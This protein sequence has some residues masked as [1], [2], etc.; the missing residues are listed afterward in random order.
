ME[1]KSRDNSSNDVKLD[2]LIKWVLLFEVVYFGAS[3][4]LRE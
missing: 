4:L 2:R 3:L 1:L